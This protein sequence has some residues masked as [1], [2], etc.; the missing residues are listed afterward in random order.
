[1]EEKKE[2]TMIEQRKEDEFVMMLEDIISQFDRMEV[3]RIRKFIKDNYKNFIKLSSKMDST[4]D[5]YISDSTI[6]INDD[7][8]IGCSIYNCEDIDKFSKVDLEITFR[9][10]DRH[11][12]KDVLLVK[13]SGELKGC[14]LEDVKHFMKL[15]DNICKPTRVGFFI[16]ESEE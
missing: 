16:K 10:F 7:K 5:R 4:T 11:R 8:G 1:M 2:L 3:I 12:P 13:G 6:F 15:I 9:F 14:N